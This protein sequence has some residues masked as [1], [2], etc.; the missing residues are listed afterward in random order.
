[1][2]DMAHI[3]EWISHD[4]DEHDRAELIE[5][6]ERAKEDESAALD[7]ADR[8]SGPL[9]F[10]TAG[11][12]GKMAGGE[13][14]MNRA[15]VRKAASGLIDYLQEKVGTDAF[16][17]IGFDGR[18]HSREFAEDTAAIVTAAGGRAA[19]MPR[20]LPTP[21]LAWAVRYL[22]AD[23]GVMVTASHNPPADNGYKVYLGGR[24]I[25]DNGRGVQ[26]VPPADKEIAAKIAATG[27]ADE[28]PLAEAGWST[29]DE[30]VI[31][32]YVNRA[33]SLIPSHFSSTMKIVLTSMHGVGGEIMTRVLHEAGFSNV[34][35]VAEQAEPD[36]DFPTVSFPNPEEAGA[37]DLS[38]ELAAKVGADIVLANDPDADRCSAAIKDEDG[39]RQLSGDEIGALLG[40]QIARIGA[41][42]GGTLA[43]SIV[44]SR[45]LEKIAGTHGLNF[46][47]TLTGFKWIARAPELIFGYEEAIGFCVDPEGVKDKDGI[48]ASLMLAYLAAKLKDKGQTLT[49]ELDALALKHGVHLTSPL[50]IRVDDLSL[51]PATM[52]HLRA[53]PPQEIAGSAVSVTDLADGSDDLPPTDGLLLLNETQ[54]R[55]VVRPSGTEPKVKCYLEV[56]EP[57]TTTVS[58]ARATARAR[59]EQLRSDMADALALP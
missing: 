46:A 35:V 27:Y 6:V 5:L 28:I 43:C 7:L 54:D 9:E 49:D 55:A 47:A 36:P 24:A 56:I 50:T 57:V 48:T 21:L 32:A 45:L 10:G 52:A 29:I 51:M 17:V 2:L 25:D 42:T 18:Y 38:M 59:M 41:L 40:Q 34:E 44:S 4:P 33:V 58:A 16:V 11:L 13:S 30:S 31:D 37:L 15:V 14:R 22:D 12:R 1:M 23:A 53:H 8:F 20:M 39:W 26:I 3:N 19:I